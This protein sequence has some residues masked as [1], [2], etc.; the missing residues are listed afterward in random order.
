MKKPLDQRPRKAEMPRYCFR[1]RIEN[2]QTNI[3]VV[4]ISQL[5]FYMVFA[6][7]PL[8]SCLHSI[9]KKRQDRRNVGNMMKTAMAD[10]LEISNVGLHD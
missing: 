9:L 3:G 1:L 7:L 2:S 5:S 4:G 8:R 6:R 10:Q